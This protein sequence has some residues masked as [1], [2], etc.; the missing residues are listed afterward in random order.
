VGRA[1]RSLQTTYTLGALTKVA[2]PNGVV[3]EYVID[4]RLY[5]K[6]GRDS[7]GNPFRLNE[8]ITSLNRG[9]GARVARMRP[10]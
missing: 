8:S 6:T 2:L 4:E 5:D 1:S 9:L 7:Y 10:R 3:V